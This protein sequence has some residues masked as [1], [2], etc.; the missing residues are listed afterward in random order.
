MIK[1]DDP[2]RANDVK[3]TKIGLLNL[4]YENIK[5]KPNERITKMFD[6]FSII[7][8]GRKGFGEII[9]KDKLVWKLFYSHIESRDRKRTAIIEAKDLKTLKL[10]ALMGSLLTHEIMKKGR[11]NEK[12]REKKMVEKKEVEKKKKIGIALK[13]SQEESDSSEEEDE[14]MAMLAKTFT[15]FMKSNRRIKFHR[16][17]DFKNKNKEE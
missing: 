17:G 8:N 3:E 13:A 9:P 6:H 14:E 5:M 1:P 16:K 2:M 12:K 11:D 4:S 10:D 7:V 15:Q